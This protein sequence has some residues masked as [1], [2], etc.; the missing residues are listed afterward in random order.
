MKCVSARARVQCA[1]GSRL[2]LTRGFLRQCLT[3]RLNLR[4]FQF[5]FQSAV[6]LRA[7]SRKI[8]PASSTTRPTTLVTPGR[9]SCAAVKPGSGRPGWER[10]RARRLGVAGPCPAARPKRPP[11]PPRLP[12]GPHLQGQGWEGRAVS[13]ARV[14]SPTL[15]DVRGAT[16]RNAVQIGKGGW[17]GLAP[18]GWRRL[19]LPEVSGSW[20]SGEEGWR[21]WGAPGAEVSA[22]LGLGFCSRKPAAVN[23][24][25]FHQLLV[26]REKSPDHGGGGTTPNLESAFG[27]R[28]QPRVFPAADR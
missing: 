15:R 5:F 14:R 26:T 4:G 27:G 6:I 9:P 17:T 19:F 11:R 25:R 7:K 12:R 16:R 10:P 1:L 8:S 13:S 18:S 3:F 28:A 23:L 2:F 22:G 24:L 21:W 20:A